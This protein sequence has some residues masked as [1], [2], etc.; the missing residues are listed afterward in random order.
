MEPRSE[1]A[2]TVWPCP[3]TPQDWG[4]RPQG[5]QESKSPH[6]EAWCRRLH[7]H[8]AAPNQRRCPCNVQSPSS[9]SPRPVSD[10]NHGIALS[11]IQRMSG[12]R[13]VNRRIIA[14][15]A[16]TSWNA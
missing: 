13:V 6:N 5:W 3:F 16:S 8:D 15:D 4:K 10:R 12:F 11:I 1:P 9:V 2:N 14:F 7:R